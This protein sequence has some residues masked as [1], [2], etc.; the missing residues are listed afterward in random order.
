MVPTLIIVRVGLGVSEDGAGACAGET[1]AR[2]DMGLHTHMHRTNSAR[3]M[4]SGM[5]MKTDDKTQEKTARW[6]AETIV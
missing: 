4:E 1:M 6:E 2:S 3:S 5:T